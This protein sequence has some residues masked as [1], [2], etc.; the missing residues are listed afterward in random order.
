VFVFNCFSGYVTSI[1]NHEEK[2]LLCMETTHQ[3]RRNESANHLINR[4]KQRYSHTPRIFHYRVNAEFNGTVMMKTHNRKMYIV[5]E[6]DFDQS[7]TSLLEDRKPPITRADFY[8]TK[9]NITIKDLEQPLFV[10]RPS[11][12]GDSREFY[13]VPE[14]CQAIGITEN[15][16]NNQTMMTKLDKY[17]HQVP[18]NMVRQMASFIERLQHTQ[19]VR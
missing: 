7:P 1:R 18:E 2:M 16:R 17:V 10:A 5:N 9:Y 15:I 8:K 12:E 11:K 19:E 4:L 13:V 6:V 3:V 14:L